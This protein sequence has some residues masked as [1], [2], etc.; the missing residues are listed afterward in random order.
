MRQYI[1]F[2]RHVVRERLGRIDGPAF[3]TYQVTLKCN[4]RCIMCDSWQTR[5]E[6]TMTVQ[7]V[8]R[9]FS[10]IGPILTLRISGGEPFVLKYMDERIRVIYGHA[11]PS[12]LHITT[13]GFLTDRI[14]SFVESFDLPMNLDMK[15]SIDGHGDVQDRIRGKNAWR[16]SFETV[17]QLAALRERKK[18]FYLG[19]NQTLSQDDPTSQYRD[20][21]KT[22]DE[23]AV[24]LH[25]IFA[26]EETPLYTPGARKN[27]A[28]DY[29]GQMKL[30]NKQYSPDL[31]IELLD[32]LEEHSRKIPSMV[33]RWVLQ[34]YLAGLRNRLLY[35]DGTPNPKCLAL[36]R[37]LRILPNGDVPVCYYNSKRAGNL[38]GADFKEFWFGDTL[39]KN[40]KW[41]RDC[42]GCWAGCEISP[43]ALLTG[44]IFVARAKRILGL[45]TTKATAD[46]APGK[47][48]STG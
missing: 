23:I 16:R 4:A 29:P 30:F 6:D 2:L 1:Q 8:D 10:Q 28:P 47:V 31:L 20:L 41:V 14:V 5:H 34:N 45:G 46:R 38:K 21:K 3:V 48:R 42:P 17:K 9:L 15:V 37:H 40:R 32:L 44:D 39:E 25:T 36:H 18:R 11:K 12:Y 7:D 22:L 43:N 26:F 33:E 13:N 35:E 19:V 27:V 24:P